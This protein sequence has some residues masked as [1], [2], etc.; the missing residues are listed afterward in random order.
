RALE[1]AAKHG[2]HVDTVLAFRKKYLESLDVAEDKPNFLQFMK[3]VDLK[4]EVVNA[5]IE[6]EYQKERNMTPS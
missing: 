2:N 3:D 6:E 4:W 5:K 1:L